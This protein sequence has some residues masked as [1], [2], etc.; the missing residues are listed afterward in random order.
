[1]SKILLGITG[2]IAAYKTPQLV[3]ELKKAGHSVNVI[4]SKSAL[5]FV[6]KLSLE[7]VSENTVYTDEDVF[8]GKV[9]HLSLTK[10]AEI[11][12]I[13]PASA[14]TIAKC[15]YGICDSLL[16]ESFLAFKGIKC[17]APAMHTEMWENP[18]TQGNI[19]KLRA[20]DVEFIGPES[21]ELA[22]SDI[23]IG[24]MS[25]LEI[26]IDKINSLKFK[27]LPLEGKSILIT[28]G[29]TKEALDSVRVLTNLSTGKLGETLAKL[30]VLMGAKV[31][32][33]TTKPV[34]D[35]GFTSYAEVNSVE[36]LKNEI[37]QKLPHAQILYMS[38]AVSDYTVEK[39]ST[40]L[41]RKETLELKL[42]G[43]IDILKS[44]SNEKKNKTFIGFCLADENLEETA[45]K[46][47]SE[48]NLDYIIANKSETIGK[49]TRSISIYQ[50]DSKKG[51]ELKN[52]P[53]D[54]IAYE[55]LKLSV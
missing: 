54:E 40:K 44:L 20:L 24:R 35:P 14:N 18:I 37:D 51:R 45:L 38:A 43:T 6:S 17:I 33:I 32:F 48:K 47:L 28:A 36:E 15:A 26:I 19:A 13:A 55:I 50:K 29:G 42:K 39:S 27:K 41:K 11:F 46:K 30:A 22:C 8:S 5:N 10:N 25:D 16:T 31:H 49:E 52:L 4:L 21:G 53:L 2:S 1:M 23:G 12:L 9:P 34:K 3:R 7:I